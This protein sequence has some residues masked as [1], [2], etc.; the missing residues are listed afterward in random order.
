MKTTLLILALV[1][2]AM[3]F[4]RLM[5]VTPESGPGRP[6][7]RDVGD[8]SSEGGHYAVRPSELVEFPVLIERIEAT[9]RTRQLAEGV[10]LHHSLFWGFPDVTHVWQEA[11]HVHIASHLVVGRADFGANRRRIEGWLSGLR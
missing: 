6:E 5:P 10:Y 2:A 1:G 8:Y 9:P 11:D 4:F 3:A 7:I